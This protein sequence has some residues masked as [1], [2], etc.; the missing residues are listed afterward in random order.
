MGNNHTKKGEKD[1]M[2]SHWVFTIRIESS[3]TP[4]TVD[5]LQELERLLESSEIIEDA[6]IRETYF[7]EVKEKG[8]Q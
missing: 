3:K 5:I 2:K 7:W 8:K 4:Y 1:Q 6:K